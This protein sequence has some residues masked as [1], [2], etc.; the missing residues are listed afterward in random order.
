M[1]ETSIPKHIAFIMDGNGRWAKGRG[2]PRAMGHRKGAEVLREVIRAGSRLGV[3][4]MTFYCF[5][6]ENWKRPEDEVEGLMN[7][8]R[9]YLKSDLAEFHSAGIRL[10]IIGDRAPLPE[11]IVQ[12]IEQSEEQTADNE[13][14]T[15]CM[16][17]S[18]GSRQ[19]ISSA[20]QALAIKVR[21]GV[22]SPQDITPEKIGEELYTAGI[23][24]PD[25]LIRTSGETRISNFLLWQLAYSE[26]VFLDKY[27]PEFSKED[28]W[29]AVEEYQR[30]DRRY[31]VALGTA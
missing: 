20:A 15:V 11:D 17:I 21:D 13:K 18:Y 6:S 22:L 2:L 19:E 31:G 28:L 23:P 12:L 8:L 25:L 14:M 5:S 7:L 10:K 9:R 27:W 26:M 16:A 1:S 29:S 30:R 3:S 4:T 24:D